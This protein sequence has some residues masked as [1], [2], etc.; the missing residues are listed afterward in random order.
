[1]NSEPSPDHTVCACKYGCDPV[2]L[3]GRLQMCMQWY[4]NCGAIPYSEVNAIGTGE[5]ESITHTQHQQQ[6]F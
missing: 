3:G 1:V 5:H 2:L 4:L 6:G